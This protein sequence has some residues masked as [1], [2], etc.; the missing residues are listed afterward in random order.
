MNCS[1]GFRPRRV[2]AHIALFLGTIFTTFL[3]PAYGQEADPTWYNPWAPAATAAVQTVQP[4]QATQRHQK[5]QAKV[6]AA[7]SSQRAG[8]ARAKAATQ[9]RPS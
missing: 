1:K 4:K 7:S 8:K 3:V 6:K 2:M 9:A 5:Q